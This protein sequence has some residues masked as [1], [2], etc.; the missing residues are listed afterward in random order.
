M[1]FGWL[2]DRFSR[3]R[4]IGTAFLVWSGATACFG[5]SHGPAQLMLARAGVGLGEAAGMGSSHSLLMDYFPYSQRARAM[6]IYGFGVPIGVAVGSVGGGWIAGLW[7]WRAAFLIAGGVGI[8][9]AILFKLTVREPARIVREGESSTPLPF[10]RSIAIML[11]KPGYLF[12]VFGCTFSAIATLAQFFWFPSYVARSFDGD[13]GR[14]ATIFG[15][16]QFAGGISGALIG[17]YISDRWAR[18]NPA[19]PTLVA[20][21]GYL[22]AC[23]M[24]IMVALTREAQM[25]WTFFLLTTIAT[26]IGNGPIVAAI[27]YFAGPTLRGTASA[28]LTFCIMVLAMGLGVPLVGLLSDRLAQTYGDESLRYALLSLPVCYLVGGILFVIAAR[29]MVST[30]YLQE[31][32]GCSALTAGNKS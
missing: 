22:A 10:L 30:P 25:A 21:F 12:V 28:M 7:G 32:I 18:A 16:I 2:S 15:A 27:Q 14:T 26:S 3:T 8:M 17:G 4:I 13:M 24:V 20:G 6:A 9:L 5:L 29:W 19:A 1:P 11:A 31:R 23:P